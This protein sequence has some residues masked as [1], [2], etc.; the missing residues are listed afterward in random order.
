[1]NGCRVSFFLQ[2][3]WKSA[4]YW[5]RAGCQA[6]IFSNAAEPGNDKACVSLGFKAAPSAFIGRLHYQSCGIIQGRIAG[7]PAGCK[8][9]FALLLRQNALYNRQAR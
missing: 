2:L 4:A 3:F 5:S 9:G 8:Q 1:L 7:C 6:G